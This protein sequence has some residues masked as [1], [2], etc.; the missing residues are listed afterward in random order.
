MGHSCQIRHVVTFLAALETA[1]KD[2]GITPENDGVD[3][4]M[5]IIHG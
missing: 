2:Q 4:A 1:L 3:A 5:K